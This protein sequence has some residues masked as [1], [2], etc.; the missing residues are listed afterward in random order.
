MKEHEL[1][2]YV[3]GERSGRLEYIHRWKFV[4][5]PSIKV[6]RLIEEID[7]K[8]SLKKLDKGDAEKATKSIKEWLFKMTPS[9]IS[10]DSGIWNCSEFDDDDKKSIQRQYVLGEL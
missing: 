1:T 6:T 8:E 5:E 10:S 4:I 7:G 3:G 2:V 9:P